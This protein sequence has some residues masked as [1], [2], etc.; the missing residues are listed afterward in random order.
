[1]FAIVVNLGWATIKIA[2]SVGALG[3]LLGFLSGIFL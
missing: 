2:L 1:M 3:L